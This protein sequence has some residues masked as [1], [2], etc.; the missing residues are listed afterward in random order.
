MSFYNIVPSE[1]FRNIAF[2]LHL[3]QHHL[4]TAIDYFESITIICGY[5]SNLE[6]STI[7]SLTYLTDKK[8][9]LQSHGGVIR[10]QDFTI[11][12]IAFLGIKETIL[13]LFLGRRSKFT[14]FI[15]RFE[16]DWINFTSFF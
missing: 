4:T 12:E 2:C 1:Y 9:I 14:N 7:S 11:R 8:E 5:P 15:N 3:L 10:K 16:H 6:Y 13:F